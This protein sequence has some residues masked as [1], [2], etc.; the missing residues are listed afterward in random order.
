MSSNYAYGSQPDNFKEY[1][2]DMP[3]EVRLHI[4]TYKDTTV[5]HVP[6]Y[7]LYEPFLEKW[8]FKYLFN[9]KDQPK[10]REIRVWM[11]MDVDEIVEIYPE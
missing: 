1:F 3:Y 9:R 6:T 11:P 2:T 4:I 8:L 5:E 10:L 7:D